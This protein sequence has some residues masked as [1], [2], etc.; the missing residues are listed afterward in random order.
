MSNVGQ[1]TARIAWRRYSGIQD[2]LCIGQIRSVQTSVNLDVMRY[3]TLLLLLTLAFVLV[4]VLSA[5]G[6]GG[7]GG[8]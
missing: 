6:G 2:G 1:N 8:Y 4:G 3:R 5:C 7:G